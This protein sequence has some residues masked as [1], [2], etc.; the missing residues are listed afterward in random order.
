MWMRWNSDAEL[1]ASFQPLKDSVT[2]Y[3]SE[4]MR[5]FVL[6]NPTVTEVWKQQLFHKR[7]KTSPQFSIASSYGSALF[8][9]REFTWGPL[10][11]L[12]IPGHV[13]KVKSS[14]LWKRNCISLGKDHELIMRAA[15]KNEFM[16]KSFP[17][18]LSLCWR[19]SAIWPNLQDPARLCINSL[20]HCRNSVV[21]CI[22]WKAGLQ[23]VR[24]LLLL[25]EQVFTFP[26]GHSVLP[27]FI[28]KIQHGRK[29]STSLHSRSAK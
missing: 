24:R 18:Y 17:V 23:V 19:H 15:Y 6:L 9:E 16:F 21:H 25:W 1:Q 2:V 27:E 13:L 5:A 10:A 4:A 7:V 14:F 11:I 28:R 12:L 26:V 20:V 3:S 22:H 29:D 8:G